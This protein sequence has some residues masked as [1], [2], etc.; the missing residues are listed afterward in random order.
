[1]L[2]RSQRR[3]DAAGR[4]GR[5]HRP[6]RHADSRDHLSADAHLVA[7]NEEPTV[8]REPVPLAAQRGR[9]HPNVAED[10]RHS[11]RTSVE[12]ETGAD[13]G[14]AAIVAGQ[15]ADPLTAARRP[16]P[17][18]D[19]PHHRAT[20][21][22]NARH[23]LTAARRTPQGGEM[24]DSPRRITRLTAARSRTHHGE[25]YDSP[26]RNVRLTEGEGATRC[27]GGRGSASGLPCGR[28]RRGWRPRLR[29]RRGPVPAPTRERARGPIPHRPRAAGG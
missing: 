18:R 2:F 15:P 22:T 25:T 28:H 17:P 4:Y 12:L 27:R 9:D 26:R 7:A 3:R 19:A 23:P 5:H 14:H 29:C 6:E 13:D 1:M 16:S 24:A 10:A 8:G 21:L 20:P 11:A